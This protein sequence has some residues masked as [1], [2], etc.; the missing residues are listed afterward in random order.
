M[1]ELRFNLGHGHLTFRIHSKQDA[2]KILV[3][4]RHCN[5]GFYYNQNDADMTIIAK[6]LKNYNQINKTLKQ[7]GYFDP[8]SS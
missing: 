1:P 8:G 2:I 5:T 6:T 7:E 4:L 3:L